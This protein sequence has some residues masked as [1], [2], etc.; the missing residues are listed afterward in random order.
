MQSSDPDIAQQIISLRN[1]MVKQNIINIQPVVEE[2]VGELVVLYRREMD[3]VDIAK[4][5]RYPPLLTLRA[6]LMKRGCNPDS[7]RQLFRKGVIEGTRE[8]TNDARYTPLYPR[9]LRQYKRAAAHDIEAAEV[10][11]RVVREADALEQEFVG[12]L[13]ALGLKFLTQEQLVAEA[14]TRGEQPRLTPD[15]LFID[16]VTIN[17]KRV[18]W[19]DYKS[20]VGSSVKFLYVANKRQAAKYTAEWGPGALCYGLSYVEGL[21]VKGAQI[22]DA[23]AIFATAS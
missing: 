5:Y 16:K 2:S 14:R 17:G 10:N 1:A 8:T 21:R 19:I 13:A 11:A 7:V 18:A 20:Y 9:D 23:R 22:L 12:A 4:M 15:V 3:I 6:I